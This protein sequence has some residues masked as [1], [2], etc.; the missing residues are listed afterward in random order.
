MWAAASL[1]QRTGPSRAD[2]GCQAMREQPAGWQPVGRLHE[3]WRSR[4]MSPRSLSPLF[5]ASGLLSLGNWAFP[6]L[7]GAVV[8]PARWSRRSV[9]AELSLSGLS[10]RCCWSR[11]GHGS[12][13]RGGCSHRNKG[14][15]WRIPRR[16]PADGSR[17]AGS[18]AF[19]TKMRACR[20]IFA[21]RTLPLMSSSVPRMNCSSSQPTR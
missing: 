21:S 20:V 17:R 5:S 15:R 9:E 1:G 6:F 12:A 4:P 8:S 3:I 13:G 7:H 16:T 19:P 14:G 2:K 11:P 18:T 10:S